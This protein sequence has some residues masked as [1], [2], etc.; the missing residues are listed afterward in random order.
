MHYLKEGSAYYAPSA[1]VAQMVEAIA[2]DKKRILPC[3]AW[4]EGAYG[5]S[6]IY[7]GV[8]CK[9]GRH[10]VE[11]VVEVELTTE[12]RSAL[13]KSAEHVRETIDKIKSLSR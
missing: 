7:L 4:L 5:F 13:E 6:E 1:A 12:E 2:L 10:G 9:L 8:P 11:E 3:A